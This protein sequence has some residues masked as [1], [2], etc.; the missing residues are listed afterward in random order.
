MR[1]FHNPGTFRLF[2]KHSIPQVSGSFTIQ[3]KQVLDIADDKQHCNKEF[4]V[5][6]SSQL[7]EGIFREVLFCKIL[8]KN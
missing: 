2:S 7:E 8:H 6:G 1:N 5:L 4:T 3:D